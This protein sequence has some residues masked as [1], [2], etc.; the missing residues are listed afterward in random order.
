VTTASRDHTG[1]GTTR[2]YVVD[3]V[4][5]DGIGTEVVPAAV[6]CVDHLAATFGFTIEWRDRDSTAPCSTSQAFTTPP[7]TCKP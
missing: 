1:T 2:R 3:V 4:P 7:I 5:G 6:R